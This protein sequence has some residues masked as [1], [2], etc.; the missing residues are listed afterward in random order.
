ML[1][2]LP[3]DIELSVI[4]PHIFGTLCPITLN[5][6]RAVFIAGSDSQ[7]QTFGP[8]RTRLKSGQEWGW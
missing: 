8:Y 5:T 3:W 4:Q 6:P 7:A 2:W 1:V